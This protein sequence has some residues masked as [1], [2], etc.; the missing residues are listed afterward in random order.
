LCDSP[1][2][3][4]VPQGHLVRKGESDRERVIDDVVSLRRQD[5]S[6]VNTLYAIRDLEG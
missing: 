4:L 5:V 3:G 2:Y 1:G 6:S